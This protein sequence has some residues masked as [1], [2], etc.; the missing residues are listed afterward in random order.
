MP[1]PEYPPE[2]PQAVRM[3]RLVVEI[4]FEIHHNDPRHEFFE[5][6][7]ELARAVGKKLEA[8]LEYDRIK[9]VSDTIKFPD[10][11]VFVQSRKFILDPPK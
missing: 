5:T 6:Q 1:T 7:E 3:I 4:G 2:A 8:D 10:G 11:R 9:V